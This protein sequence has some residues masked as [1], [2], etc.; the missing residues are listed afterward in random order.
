MSTFETPRVSSSAIVIRA[1]PPPLSLSRGFHAGRV[2][3]P[4][5]GHD[6]VAPDDERP[7]FA[8]GARD[9]RVDKH[10]LNLLRAAGE[11]VARTPRSYLKP[12]ERRRNPP[13]PPTHFAVE[14]DRRVLEPEAVV[15]A[16]RLDAPA[17]VDALRGRGV[18]EELGDCR[19]QRLPPVEHPEQVLVGARMDPAQQGQDLVADQPAD[20]VAVRRVLAKRQAVFVAV[21]SRVTSPDA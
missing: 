2:D 4:R 8:L 18:R 20:A 17:E 16:N 7:L 21:A 5:H 15:L 13:R 12:W 10:V 19:R 3:D 1:S 9:L 11:P 14:R 6:L